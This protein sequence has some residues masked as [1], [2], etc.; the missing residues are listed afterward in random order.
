MAKRKSFFSKGETETAHKPVQESVAETAQE[1]EKTVYEAPAAIEYTLG[2]NP[3]KMRKS[4]GKCGGTQIIT[5][6]VYEEKKKVGFDHVCNDCKT[7]H[8]ERF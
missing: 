7:L 6:S 5:T 4:C 8:K 2:F 1:E 3:E